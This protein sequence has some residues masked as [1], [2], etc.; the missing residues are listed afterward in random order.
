MTFEC[1]TFEVEFHG[2]DM[3]YASVTEWI[4]RDENRVVLSI[5]IGETP[6]EARAELLDVLSETLHGFSALDIVES[7][8]P[9][10]QDHL[11]RLLTWQLKSREAWE[12]RPADASVH[13][14]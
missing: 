4:S 3:F 2:R 5:G 13:G 8:D 6:G 1:V 12:L 11:A 7:A 9:K 10:R 14:A